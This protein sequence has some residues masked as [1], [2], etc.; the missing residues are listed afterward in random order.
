MVTILCNPS[1]KT[2]TVHTPYMSDPQ[3]QHA[4]STVATIEDG[5]YKAKADATMEAFFAAADTYHTLHNGSQTSL[6]AKQPGQ[7]RGG[8]VLNVD[9]AGEVRPQDKPCRFFKKGNCK[10]GADCPYSHA[11]IKPNDGYAK[12]GGKSD[13]HNTGKSEKRKKDAPTQEEIKVMKGEKCINHQNGRCSWGAK[14]YRI[15]DKA[16]GTPPS[17]QRRHQSSDSD[18]EPCAKYLTG[19]CTDKSCDRPHL[20]SLRRSITRQLKQPRSGSGEVMM[21]SR[22]NLKAAAQQDEKFFDGSDDEEILVKMTE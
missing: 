3:R 5:R 18:K 12:S 22:G 19:N 14:C 4:C 7:P 10:K 16:P 1:T 9:R 6:G 15:H 8:G 11:N 2:D 21:I 13:K 20:E 17:K